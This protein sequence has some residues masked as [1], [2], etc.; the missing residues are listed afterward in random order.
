MAA[1]LEVSS[2]IRTRFSTDIFDAK[3]DVVHH[4]KE[5][6]GEDGNNGGSSAVT[7]TPPRAIKSRIATTTPKMSILFN[8]SDDIKV[9]YFGNVGFVDSKRA[10]S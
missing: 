5:A 4:N 6:S 2:T 8:Q 7:S 10:H 3:T 1:L 9:G